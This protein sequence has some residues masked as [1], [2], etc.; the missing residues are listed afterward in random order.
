[1][2]T[3]Y[4]GSRV[5]LISSSEV[6]YEGILY[7][8]DPKESTVALQSVKC[9]GTED[10]TV[11]NG[12][13]IPASDTVY[14]FIIFKGENIKHLHVTDTS[15][16]PPDDPAI[17]NVIE[18]QTDP[19]RQRDFGGG[20]KPQQWTLS[21]PQRNRGSDRGYDRDRREA[22][23]QRPENR[24]PRRDERDYGSRRS[25][26]RQG[27][28]YD[29]REDRDYR[30]RR[31]QDRYNGRRDNYNRGGYDDSYRGYNNRNQQSRNGRYRD[32]RRPR[33]NRG[34]SNNVSTG[35]RKDLRGKEGKGEYLA[36][37]DRSRRNE[38]QIDKNTHF[39][40]EAANQMFSNMQIDDDAGEIQDQKN[41]VQGPTDVAK[42]DAGDEPQDVET[43]EHHQLGQDVDPQ[44]VKYDKS[45]SFFDDLSTDRSVRQHRKSRNEQRTADKEA[46]GDVA[47]NYQ[48]KHQRRRYGRNRYNGGRRGG[49]RGRGGRGRGR[50]R[51]WQNRQQRQEAT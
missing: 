42:D 4:L 40:F 26:G 39:D 9:C 5:S 28:G 25:Q 41:E 51:R 3:P 48:S 29:D 21:S 37:G 43:S 36:L 12:K 1:M 2:A 10:R 24:P 20:R 32:N 38:I 44:M 17:M 45:N 18:R 22:Y 46:F 49:Y 19:P 27:Y 30:P 16:V 34:N 13:K 8:I 50:G 11:Q 6:R 33:D 35:N 23:P 14:E 47:Q 7:T 15:K 31:R